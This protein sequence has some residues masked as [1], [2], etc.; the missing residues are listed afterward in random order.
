MN[1]GSRMLLALATAGLAT[2]G[3]AMSGGTIVGQLEVTQPNGGPTYVPRDGSVIFV[4]QEVFDAHRH[5]AAPNIETDITSER[6]QIDDDKRQIAAL[7]PRLDEINA[8]MNAIGFESM[9]SVEG[10]DRSAIADRRFTLTQDIET[11][12]RALGLLETGAVYFTPPPRKVLAK[13]VLDGQGQFKIRV[14]KN[15]TY[16]MMV[17]AHGIASAATDFHYWIKKVELQKGRKLTVK[18]S[19]VG[20]FN[21]EKP[22]SMFL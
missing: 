12:T 8:K 21:V 7:Q 3:C 10:K 13:T 4:T 19:N 5:E 2:A 17:T 15:G 9:Q 1:P 22:S 20:E 18:L 11:V 16:I 14:P 6:R